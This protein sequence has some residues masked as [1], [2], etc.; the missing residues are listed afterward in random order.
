[1]ILIGLFFLFGGIY[2]G[3]F[4]YD[5]IFALGMV[6]TGIGLCIFGYTDGF[7]DPTPKGLFL[8]RIAIVA[9]LVGI[10]IVIYGAIQLAK[11]D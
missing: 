11:M 1:M 8:Y 3:L 4:L 7:T 9:F 6:A 2:Y 10:P 5:R